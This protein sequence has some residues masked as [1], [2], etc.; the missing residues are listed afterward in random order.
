M[1]FV[2]A[3]LRASTQEQNAER[4]RQSL[5]EFA[6]SHNLLIAKFYVENESGAKLD[7]PKLNELLDDCQQGDILLI[8]DIDRL[9]RLNGADW[10]T[11]R[12]RIKS[13]QI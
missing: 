6:A 7:R 12:N 11:L 5:I 2:R 3:Y 13:K 4:A 10:K 8:E 9:S 1:M